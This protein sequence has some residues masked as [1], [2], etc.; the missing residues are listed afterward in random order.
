M[1]SGEVLPVK[2]VAKCLDASYIVK[3]VKLKQLITRFI[4]HNACI[5][6]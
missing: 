1:E 3:L 4:D 5:L 6:F 2:W